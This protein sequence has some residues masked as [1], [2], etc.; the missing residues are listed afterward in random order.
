[1]T[2]L[3]GHHLPQ[4]HRQL[5]FHSKNGVLP[6]HQPQTLAIPGGFP[7]NYMP[8]A[9]RSQLQHPYKI[10]KAIGM[11]IQP[12]LNTCQGPVPDAFLPGGQP[13]FFTE[14]AYPLPWPAVGGQNNFNQ[15]AFGTG[16]QV[17]PNPP[18]NF[19]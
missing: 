9:A 2:L 18:S 19:F 13:N 8:W 14:P 12:Q 10:P 5:V 16:F 7:A 17:Q 15:A 3:L 1:M 4:C 11:P 6:S